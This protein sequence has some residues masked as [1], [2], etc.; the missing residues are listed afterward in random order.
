MASITPNHF[1]YLLATKQIDF[2]NDTFKIRLM[3]SGFSFNR[4]AD[5]V[6]ADVSASELANGFG[7]TTGGSTL[8]N[9]VVTEDDANDRTSIV[10]DS[11]DWTASGGSIGPSPGAIIIDDTVTN[12]PIVAYIQFSEEKTQVTGS[13]F[14]VATPGLYIQG[15]S[16]DQSTPSNNIYYLLATKAVDFSADVFKIRLMATGFTFD[17]DAHELWATISA[18]EHANGNG[19]TTGGNTLGG[20]AIAVNDTDDRVEITWNDTY[21]IA[22]GADLGPTPGA[23][24]IDDTVANDPI[25][26]Y[27]DFGGEQ[28]LADGGKG[29]I[30]NPGVYL[31][32]A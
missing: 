20:V 7:Y 9:V 14:T 23:I 22:S 17:K 24:I 4:D 3:T 31:G 10:W 21:W 30:T 32:A 27:I 1:F 29:T 13:D 2:A 8:A 19:Y 11:V 6:W 16:T 25:V 18:S 5:T 28:T 26:G 15:D 12:D